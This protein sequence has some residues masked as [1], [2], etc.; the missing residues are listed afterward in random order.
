MLLK[1]LS[2]EH[3]A[4]AA[5]KASVKAQHKPKDKVTLEAICDPVARFELPIKKA[6]EETQQD[7]VK[8]EKA[9]AGEKRASCYYRC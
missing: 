6:T 9:Q 2:Q 8:R 4:H 5:R 7:R 1:H 3:A